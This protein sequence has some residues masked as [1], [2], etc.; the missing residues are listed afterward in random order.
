[1]PNAK[2]FNMA[3]ENIGE[4]TL[5]DAVFGVE[6]NQSVLHDALNNCYNQ[7]E[8]NVVYQCWFLNC[9]KCMMLI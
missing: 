3:A 6:P 4:V 2:L 8:P 9:D 7:E 1:M 5:S